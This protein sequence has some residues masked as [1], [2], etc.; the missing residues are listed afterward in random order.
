MSAT[1]CPLQH[2]IEFCVL[3]SWPVQY[4]RRSFGG[5]EKW[6]EVNDRGVVELEVKRSEEVLIQPV[7]VM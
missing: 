2:S 4:E 6:I 3:F 1:H 7:K 5:G